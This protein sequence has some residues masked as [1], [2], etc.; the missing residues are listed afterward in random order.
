MFSNKKVS[1]GLS[2]DPVE[3]IVSNYF[4]VR[5][6]ARWRGREVSPSQAWFT[7]NIDDCVRSNDVECQV[8]L[9]SILYFI[10]HNSY[11]YLITQMMWGMIWTT[12]G[13]VTDCPGAAANN[14]YSS[15]WSGSDK[16]WFVVRLELAGDPRS[17]RWDI[18]VSAVTAR[19]PWRWCG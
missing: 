7:K 2:R 10:S 8:R 4:Y 18:S 1:S 12:L 14:I 3:R 6:P 13:L 9:I 16:I 5:S 15:P 17:T 11:T 19:L